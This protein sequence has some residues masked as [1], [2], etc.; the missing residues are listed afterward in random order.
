MVQT[1]TVSSF[2]TTR[3]LRGRQRTCLPQRKPGSSRHCSSASPG[4]DSVRTSSTPPSSPTGR[5]EACGDNP[6]L[7]QDFEF[8][9]ARFLGSSL[10]AVSDPNTPLAPPTYSGAQLRRV[11]DISR[12]GLAAAIHVATHVASA[13]VRNLRQAHPPRVLPL[14][15]LAWRERIT[16][17]ATAL[18]LGDVIR[19]LW[20]RGIPVIPLDVLPAPSFRVWPAWL[21]GGRQS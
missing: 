4:P 11:R 12:N 6:A 7:V 18:Q 19:D 2:A 5:D 14:D 9:V 8:R 13:T 15:G 16:R 17:L 3:Q 21:R 1:A 10:D 20:T